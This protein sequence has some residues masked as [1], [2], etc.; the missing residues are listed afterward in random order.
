MA[1]PEVTKLRASLL[2]IPT[3]SAFIEWSFSPLKS[4]HTYLYNVQTQQRLIK[5]SLMTS[6]KKIL[7]DLEK[8]LNSY[9][10]YDSMIHIFTK[11]IVCMELKYKV[12]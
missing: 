1:L 5:S 10:F 7:Q 4:V 12:Q 11:K 6:R 3:T 9:E 8:S 2:I